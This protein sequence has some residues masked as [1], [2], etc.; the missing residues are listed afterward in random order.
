MTTKRVPN[1]IIASTTVPASHLQPGDMIVEANGQTDLELIV[2]SVKRAARSRDVQVTVTSRKTP[3]TFK[4]EQELVVRRDMPTVHFMRCRALANVGAAQAVAISQVK[5]QEKYVAQVVHQDA[6]R[7]IGAAMDLA[8]ARGK[9]F[10]VE[11]FA[12]VLAARE[13]QDC[14]V[15]EIVDALLKLRERMVTQTLGE[16]S[17]PGSR[18]TST[19][20]NL[21]DDAYRAGIADALVKDIWNRTDLMYNIEILAQLQGQEPDA[22]A[23]GYGRF[24]DIGA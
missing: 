16:I 4:P 11:R 5:N 21:A 6:A 12:A 8:S 17:R 2:K 9:L 3:Y 24:G 1:S 23:F 7:V 14:T 20:S 22:P 19:A 13:E 15:E 18:S 10:V